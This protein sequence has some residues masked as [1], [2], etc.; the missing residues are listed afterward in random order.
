METLFADSFCYSSADGPIDAKKLTNPSSSKTT[1]HLA[2]LLKK[3]SL[4][5]HGEGGHGPGEGGS[6]PL[7]ALA[8]SVRIDR[9]DPGDEGFHYFFSFSLDCP[10]DFSLFYRPIF[11]SRK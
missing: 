3:S 4:N 8:E 11:E 10:D 1:A 7:E 5:D 2:G 9:K 6:D